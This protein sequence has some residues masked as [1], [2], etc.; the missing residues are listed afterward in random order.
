MKKNLL[1]IC[2]LF[3]LQSSACDICG[4]STGNYFIGP[5]P[6]F[7]KHFFGIRYTFRSFQSRAALDETQFSKDFY[8]TTE[9]WA[10]YNIG[11]K[12]QLLAFVPY[13]INKQSS[14]DGIKKSNG[15]GDISVIA[16]YN[17]LN[18]KKNDRHANR[19]S[20]QLLIG[21]GIKMPTG[22]FA[23]DANDLI[24]TANNQAGTG[25]VDFILNV[26]YT[27]HIND[28]GI[29]TN[30]NYKINQNANQYKFG[31]R[32]SS[33]IFL[34]HSIS[35]AKITF[36][37]NVGVLYENLKSNELN[38]MKVDDTGGNALLASGGMEINFSKMAIGCNAQ[39]PVSQNFS[40][41]QTITKI[42]GMAHV[43]LTF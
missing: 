39:L 28:W 32:L 43:T 36:N 20:Q 41:Q 10:G 23:V 19:I 38:K 26:M 42:R 8:Q 25:S 9:L 33:G 2:I 12:W 40:N 15:L 18:A 6:Q 21:G 14:D 30:L 35:N 4:C 29:N 24:P 17:L 22:K 34:F 37:P 16:N 31:N 1:I 3:S 11:R 27:Y 13:N 5:F 7:S